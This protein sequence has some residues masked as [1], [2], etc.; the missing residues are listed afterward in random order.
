[1]KFEWDE[2]KLISTT[3]SMAFHFKKPRLSS[4]T[5]L[6]EPFQTQIILIE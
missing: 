2:G 1:M 6:P 4:E 3:A 5:S